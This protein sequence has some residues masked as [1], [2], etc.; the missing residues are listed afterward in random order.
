AYQHGFED[1]DFDGQ[2]D[3]RFEEREQPGVNQRHTWHVDRGKFDLLLLQHAQKL[4]AAVYDGVKVSSIDFA[5][6]ATPRV[7]FSM[8]NKEMSL[9]ANMVVDASGRQTLLGNQLKLKQNDKV[10]NQYALH[11]WFDGYDRMALAK[12]KD[13]ESY[14]YIH[15]LPVTN[16][17]IWQIPITETVTSIGVVTQRQNFEKSRESRENFFWNCCKSRPELYEALK[18]SRQVR[19]FKE[20]GDYSYGM[21]EICGDGFAMIGDAAR[22]VDPIFSSG[23]SIA[24]TSAK[25]AT[26]DIIRA[27]QNGGFSK[28]SFATYEST[29]RKGTNNWYEFISVYYRLNVLFT[30]FLQDPRYRIQVLK[31][32]QGDLY[33][34]EKPEVLNI[35]KKTVTEVE[36][37]PKH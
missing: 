24:M 11:T 20:E 27:A 29:M 23:V 30:A 7:K 9:S 28:K 33:D 25:L 13:L 21:S 2:A 12:S 15:F 26:Q 10:F 17:W 3:I 6:T 16:T 31:L 1:A 36:Q 4:G 37:N 5:E 19:P 8:G 35:M 34:D 32:L 22:F 14:I 18:K